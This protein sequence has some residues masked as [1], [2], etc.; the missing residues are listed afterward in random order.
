MLFDALKC[1]EWY[2]FYTDLL[3]YI[4]VWK[5]VSQILVRFSHKEIFAIFYVSALYCI[6][7][8]SYILSTML[9]TF[10][11]KHAN[12]KGPKLEIFVAGTFTQIRPVWIGYLESRP[13]NPKVY[14]WVLIFSFISRDF[15]FS[16]VGDIAKKYKFAIFRPKPSKFLILFGLVPKSPTQ[17][18]SQTGLICVKPNISS[19]GH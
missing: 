6:S 13:K 15:Y 1:V 7:R 10:K 11:K 12:L 14:V 16:A 18:R 5:L 19:L 17:S 4:F 2:R 3:F 9:L 8:K